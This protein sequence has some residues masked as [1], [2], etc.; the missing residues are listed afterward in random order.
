MLVRALT[1]Y[2]KAISHHQTGLGRD[3]RSPTDAFAR[4]K[5]QGLSQQW[6]SP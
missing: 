6:L 4:T 3:T 1:L 2:D 5:Q